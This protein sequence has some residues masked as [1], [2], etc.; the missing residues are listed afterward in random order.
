MARK[1]SEAFCINGGEVIW[2]I[3]GIAAEISRLEAQIRDA[4]GKS[5]P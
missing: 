5:T 1:K 4:Q 3:Y 2:L